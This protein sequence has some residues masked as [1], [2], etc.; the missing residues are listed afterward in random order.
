MTERIPLLI[1]AG[2]TAAG[3]TAIAVTA[4]ERLGAEIVCADSRQIYRGLDAGTAKP[5]AEERI[6][7]RHHLLDVADP[8][9]AFSVA[10]WIDLAVGAI[11]AIH[12]R[13]RLAI[14]VG[15]TGLYIRRLMHGL[16]AAPTAQE[17]LRESLAAD[18]R[19]SGA[20]TLHRRLA[21]LDS[22]SAARIHPSNVVRVIRALEVVLASGRTLSDWQ[23]SETA[24][25]GNWDA[26]LTVITRPR[27]VLRRRAD[28]RVT[29][30][31]RAG[32]R[33]EVR[34]LLAAGLT[35]DSPGMKALGYRPLALAALGH[36]A[37]DEAE[38]I[39]RRDTSRYVKRQFTWFRKDPEA[40]WFDADALGESEAVS[41]LVS[42]GRDLQARIG[43]SAAEA[44]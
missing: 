9:K 10:E 41:R 12:G 38:R 4:A 5:S 33:D 26:F 28:L 32:W 34:S 16:C 25:P 7:I 43:A 36:M 20:G 13:G 42:A 29:G 15:G 18:E 3:K 35:P 22:E 24:P 1:V 21:A 44:K 40:V 2:P 14:V 6:R 11:R 30:M 27:D 39:V 31:L 19:L 8:A 17:T 37:E 23:R